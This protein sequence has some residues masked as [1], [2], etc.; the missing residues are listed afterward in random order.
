MTNRFNGPDLKHNGLTNT[1][2]LTLKNTS[3]QVVETS[4]TN[5]S[6]FK[7]FS[8]PDYHTIRTTHVSLHADRL[9]ERSLAK[10]GV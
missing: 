5:K 9:L 8:H 2:H 3:A 7:D 4:V 10:A 6:S 1:I